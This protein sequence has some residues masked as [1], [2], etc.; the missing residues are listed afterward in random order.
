MAEFGE[1]KYGGDEW[2]DVY[3]I[4]HCTVQASGATTPH[5]CAACP[6]PNLLDLI[7][8]LE[9]AVRAA[10]N[11]FEQG[12]E[13]SPASRQHLLAAISALEERK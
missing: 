8:V 11:F 3:P 12:S 13:F 5:T 4:R 10:Y 1:C 9:K 2:I 6:I 7:A